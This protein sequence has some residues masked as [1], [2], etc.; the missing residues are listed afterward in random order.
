MVMT[1]RTQKS[2]ISSRLPLI[3]VAI[4]VV[5]FVFSFINGGWKS[6]V[7]LAVPSLIGL[8][9]LWFPH[10]AVWVPL[11]R[12]VSRSETWNYPDEST[13]RS[14]GMVWVLFVVLLAI[15]RSVFISGLH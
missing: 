2:T 1:S 12:F 15:Y 3:G 8:G 4:V 13:V 7:A 6:I 9:H 5:C 14:V 11:T 10:W